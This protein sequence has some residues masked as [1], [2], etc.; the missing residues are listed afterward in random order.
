M[1]WPD[2]F[3]QKYTTNTTRLLRITMTMPLD[4][5]TLKFEIQKIMPFS[6]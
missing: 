3:A 6:L 2:L 4:Q 5:R 1:E